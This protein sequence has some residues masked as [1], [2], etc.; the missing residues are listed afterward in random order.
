MRAEE[1]LKEANRHKDE[2]LAMVSHELRNPLAAIG[3]QIAVLR[4]ARGAPAEVAAAA[5]V[6]ERQFRQLAR[7]V[8]DL[9]DL[10]RIAEGKIELRKER[11]ALAAVVEAAVETCRTLIEAKGHT[12]A[13]TLPPEPV[14]LHADPLRLA[15]VLGN[16]IDNAAKFT[17]ASGRIWLSAQAEAQGPEAS[18]EV[19]IRVRDSG[20]G[21]PA[22]LLPRVFDLF[23]QARRPLERRRAGRRAGLGLGLTLAQTLVALHC[24]TITAKSG[25]PGRGSEFI[26]RLSCTVPAD[27]AQGKA[28]R[29]GI[30]ESASAS[31]PRRILVVE[32][33]RDVAQSL[34]MLLKSFGHHALV[35]Q[36]GASALEALA[37]FVPEV[38]I[39]DVG[40]PGMNGYELARRLRERHRDCLLIAQTG[41][42]IEEERRGEAACFDLCLTKP[43]NLDRWQEALASLSA[44][45]PE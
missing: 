26:V 27:Q 28:A 30:G 23:T 6:L 2:F 42:R 14:Y 7:L 32:D 41:Y 16:L 44:A 13:V 33:D 17:A 8:D 18:E 29:E 31:P 19:V 35:V 34:G 40:L 3:C 12:L 11:V 37:D 45:S 36:D 21:I 43:V 9:F 25:G 39:I 38:A 10:T 20:I 1:A 5:D 22:D 15:Q 24:G 4:R